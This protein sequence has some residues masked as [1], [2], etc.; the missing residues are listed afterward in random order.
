MTISWNGLSFAATVETAGH[1]RS[2][3]A[4]G[5]QQTVLD[6][7]GSRV[8]PVCFGVLVGGDLVA[9]GFAVVALFPLAG[10]RVLRTAIG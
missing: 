9:G 6:V 2:G 7:A 3:T 5:L 4:I 8:S 10:W 1:A